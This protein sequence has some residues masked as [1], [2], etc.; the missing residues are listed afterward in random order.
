MLMEMDRLVQLLESPIFTSLRME[1]PELRSTEGPEQSFRLR[2]SFLF[3]Q[4]PFTTVLS[5]F[6][7]ALR[8]VRYVLNFV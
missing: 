7:P 8:T 1:V 4:G 3:Q 6:T 5:F 2:L